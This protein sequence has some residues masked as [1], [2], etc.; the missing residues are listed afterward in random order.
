ML[1]YNV[2]HRH[3]QRVEPIHSRHVPPVEQT[4]K[5]LQPLQSTRLRERYLGEDVTTA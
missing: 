5:V 2:T 1:F 4:D 3:G